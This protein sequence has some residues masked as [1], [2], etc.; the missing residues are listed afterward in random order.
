MSK[1][2]IFDLDGTLV[3]SIKDIAI[4]AN[5]TLKEFNMPTHEIEKYNY[6]AG[7][8][9]IELMENALGEK[10][11][12][13]NLE[14]IVKK[15]KENYSKQTSYTKPYEKINE[16]LENLDSRGYN[17]AVLSNKPH[18]LTCIYVE[19][20]FPNI[21]FKE[22]HGQKEDVPKKPDPLAAN[23]II[24]SFSVLK[25]DVYFIGDTKVDMNTAKNANVKAI[26]VLWGFRGEKELRDNGAD[27][28]VND[29]MEIVDIV[30]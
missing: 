16:M 26:G 24:K 8:G 14:E 4:S 23:N 28:I 20:F 18:G 29:P 9:V 13:V 2:L 22:I 3:D 10:I 27:F 19:K 17:L 1:T 7:G 12:K 30:K 11:N 21:N 25:K 5:K 15:F 6:L